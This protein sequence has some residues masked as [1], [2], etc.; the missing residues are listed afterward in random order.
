MHEDSE[1]KQ[2]LNN[3]HPGAQTSP[4]IQLF[5]PFKASE[6]I[7]QVRDGKL[8]QVLGDIENP[9]L[10]CQVDRFGEDLK[11]LLAQAA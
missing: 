3:I 5:D 9:D 11:V 7:W 2:A 1:G 4:Q 8:V 10:V 6:Y